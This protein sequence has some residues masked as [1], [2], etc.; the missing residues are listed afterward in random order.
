[1][2]W[3]TMETAPLDGTQVEL[4]IAADPEDDSDVDVVTGYMQPELHFLE[5]RPYWGTGNRNSRNI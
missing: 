2:R 4:A 5:E 3:E 1:M